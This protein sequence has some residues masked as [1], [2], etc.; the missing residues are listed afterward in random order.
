MQGVASG[1][2]SRASIR[3]RCGIIYGTLALSNTE[4][5]HNR[6]KTAAEV[7]AQ[8]TAKIP[9][10]FF[11]FPVRVGLVDRGEQERSPV[12]FTAM[13]AALAA[14]VVSDC[15]GLPGF[16]FRQR[17]TRG[18]HLGGPVLAGPCCGWGT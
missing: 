12:F 14:V 10:L 13:V 18:L 11:C 17:G 2:S 3:S 6:E 1:G 4:R 16:S 9:G 8:T 7:G 5:E 15:P